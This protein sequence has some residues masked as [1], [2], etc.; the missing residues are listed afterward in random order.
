MG[1]AT[2]LKIR[3]RTIITVMGQ[4]HSSPSS[5]SA[6]RRSGADKR[7]ASLYNVRKVL[8]LGDRLQM[9]LEFFWVLKKFPNFLS[10]LGS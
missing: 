1:V 9:L 10:F 6:S 8:A 4:F 5:S 3:K 7:Y 2:E